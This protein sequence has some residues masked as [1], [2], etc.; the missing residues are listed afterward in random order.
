MPIQAFQTNTVKKRRVI[1]EA[2]NF[3][4]SMVLRYNVFPFGR[5]G[6]IKKSGC[7]I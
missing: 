3:K 5:K 7:E 6:L 4:N 1:I 2:E